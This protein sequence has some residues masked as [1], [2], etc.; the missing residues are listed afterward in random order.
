MISYPAGLKKL[1]LKYSIKKSLD[2]EQ[3]QFGR[4]VKEVN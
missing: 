1:C 2:L 4:D 3:G